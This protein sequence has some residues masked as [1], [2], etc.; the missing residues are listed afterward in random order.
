MLRKWLLAALGTAAVAIAIAAYHLFVMSRGEEQ[1]RL[2][3]EARTVAGK[4]SHYEEIFRWPHPWNPWRE[5]AER[6]YEA[7]GHEW[8]FFL[9]DRGKEKK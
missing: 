6:W 2:L 5:K 1:Y 3:L 7:N 9:K 8:E 4:R